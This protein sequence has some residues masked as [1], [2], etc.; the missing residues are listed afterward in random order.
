MDMVMDFAALESDPPIIGEEGLRRNL[1]KTIVYSSDR[2]YLGKV[3][4]DN[5]RG[6]YIKG[7]MRGD[8]RRLVREGDRIELPVSDGHGGSYMRK[9]QVEFYQDSGLVPDMDFG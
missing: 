8:C 9:Y 2:K 1:G 4:H 3:A 7:S 6:F 5:R